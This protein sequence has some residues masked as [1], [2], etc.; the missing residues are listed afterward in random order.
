[1]KFVQFLGFQPTVSQSKFNFFLWKLL[2]V[3]TYVGYTVFL[4][5]NK[6]KILYS[7]DLLGR[8]ADTY[9][10]C[11]SSA[12][13]L[14]IVIEPFF[15]YRN[16]KNFQEL[17]EKFAELLKT[18]GN[19]EAILVGNKKIKHKLMLI[20]VGFLI[21]SLLFESHHFIRAIQIEQARNI[22]LTTLISIIIMFTKFW[23][24]ARHL[25]TIEECLVIVKK[26]M[27]LINQ[28][29]DNNSKI[30]SKVYDKIVHKNYTN[31]IRMYKTVQKMVKTVNALGISQLT[32]FLAF[33]LYLTGD[34]YWIA[35]V[36]MHNKIKMAVT[37]GT[38]HA[39]CC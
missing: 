23:F 13:G 37:Y 38:I 8:V 33:K 16:Y 4:I 35:L 3:S 24:I 32:I 17:T 34:F 15:N 28:E 7:D 2:Q 19:F 18:H 26:S 30:N 9:K 11:I 27:I 31:V 1:M 36:T 14:V 22:Y 10:S 12:S 6:D 5:S 25:L 29:V 21:S 39:T 20:V